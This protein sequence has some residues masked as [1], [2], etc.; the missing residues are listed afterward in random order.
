VEEIREDDIG[1]GRDNGQG[2]GRHRT[3]TD[4]PSSTPPLHAAS[5]RERADAAR[6]RARDAPRGREAGQ[7]DTYY[8]QP[9]VT[10]MPFPHGQKKEE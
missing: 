2:R 3:P 7:D 1:S 9:Y 5:P 4:S 6:F 8:H 10:Q